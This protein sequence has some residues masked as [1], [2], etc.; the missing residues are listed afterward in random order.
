MGSRVF[1][2]VFGYFVQLGKVH[3][4]F[5]IKTLDFVTVPQFGRQWFERQMIV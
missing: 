3:L 5:A 1:L 4:H 2:E